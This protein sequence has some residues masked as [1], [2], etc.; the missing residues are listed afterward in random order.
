[1]FVIGL[2]IGTTS[3]CAAAIDA[4][5]GEVCEVITEQNSFSVPGKP[6]ER[7]QNADG[8][9]DLCIEAVSALSGRFDCCGVG[10]T[11]QMHGIV[12]LD[13]CGN[14]V[15]KL[16]TWQDMSG[17]ELSDGKSYAQTLSQLT[18]YNA[19]TGFG[20]TTYFVHSQKGEVP[21]NAAAIC[22]I[23]DYAAMKLCSLASPVTHSSDAA[24]L[25]LFDID[26]MTFDIGAVKKA[27]LNPS[28][29]P[30]VVSA[31]EI[32]GEFR[33]IPVCVAIG[34][35]QASFLGSVNDSEKCVLVNIGTGSQI[36]FF[37]NSKSV[38]PGTELRPCANGLIRVGSALCG[39][40]AFAAL[41]S[42]IRQAA[43]LCGAEMSSAYPFI[44]RFLAQTPAAPNP[45][46]VSTGFSGTREN[47]ESR[48]SIENIS[49]DN[50]TP[51]H[52]IY[53]VLNG[54]ADELYSMYALCGESGRTSLIGSGNGLR[55]NA[56][57]QK[58][59]SERFGMP[60][61]IPVNKEEAAY[62]AALCA[63][64]ACGKY[65]SLAAA[66]QLIKYR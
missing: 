15:S 5:S 21:E 12:Y 46:R 7:M 29:L 41:E 22:T 58:I 30:R 42:F 45:L 39:G 38:I 20:L 66:Q 9:V 51:G 4:E 49:L 44:D 27:G 16:Y 26:S 28:F 18:G 48:G 59:F 61:S 64:A 53:G 1:M 37:S 33:G 62:G 24:S 65:E 34:D 50:F 47:P 43:A 8:I 23:H 63:L 35:N 31:H 52:L 60:L 17:S 40:S 57:L 55:K 56:A 36:S 13:S 10:I 25:G 2:D 11:G 14:A 19:A 54:I 3:I 6:Y 32:I